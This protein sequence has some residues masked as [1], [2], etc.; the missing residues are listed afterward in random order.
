MKL[1]EHSGHSPRTKHRAGTPNFLVACDETG[2]AELELALASLPLCARGRVFV[3]VPT[4]GDI[5]FLAVPPR[6]TVTWLARSRRSGEPGTGEACRRGMAVA[7]AAKAW[8]AEM[9][10]TEE[11]DEASATT[12]T[13]VWLG[14]DYR[15]V[16]AVH[17]YLTD[18]LGLP[19]SA[20][21]TREGYGLGA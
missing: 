21:H 16:S 1:S 8:A 3:E 4:E 12:T 14:G 11:V 10:C 19:A 18:E 2:L 7:R 20:I 17:E 15:G 13:Q 6:M 9:L 5:G